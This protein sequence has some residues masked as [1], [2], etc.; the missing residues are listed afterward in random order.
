MKDFR[1]GTRIQAVTSPA[2][3]MSDYNPCNVPSGDREGQRG[4]AINF[5]D[6]YLQET[7]ISYN[8]KRLATIQL[9]AVAGAPAICAARNCCA[10]AELLK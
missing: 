2:F 10:A 6:F 1:F 5:C 3:R 9:A 7:V 8:S 4:K